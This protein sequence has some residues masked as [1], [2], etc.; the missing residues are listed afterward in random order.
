MSDR[1]SARQIEGLRTLASYAPR[2]WI[3]PWVIQ[4]G[5]TRRSLLWR[6]LVAARWYK[7][8]RLIG[9]TKAG[10]RMLAKNGQTVNDK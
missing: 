10:R 2:R 3:A 4:H 7:T 6:G 9:I 1:L 5:Q 8:A